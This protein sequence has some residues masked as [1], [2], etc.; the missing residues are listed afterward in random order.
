[1]DATKR[2]TAA[3]LLTFLAFAVGAHPAAGAAVRTDPDIAAFYLGG[4]CLCATV[5][6]AQQALGLADG[7]LGAAGPITGVGYPAGLL[8][9][10]DSAIGASGVNAHLDAIPDGIKITLAGTSQG[11]IVLN[12]VKQSLALRITPNRPPT[13]LSFVTFGDP[14]NATG[15]IVTR[16]PL[17]WLSVPR[18]PLPTPYATTEIVREYDGLSDWPTRPTA[19]SALNAVMGVA[20]VH[21]FYGAAANPSTPGTLKTVAT[22][23][24]GGVTTHYVVPTA[25][26]PITQPLRYMGID[27]APL[28]KWLRP[29]IDATYHQRPQTPPPTSA[30][31]LTETPVDTPATAGTTTPP[32]Q[33]TA[34]DRIR[35]V[36][37]VKTTPGIPHRNPLAAIARALTPRTVRGGSSESTA[38]KEN[39][40]Q[41]TAEHTQKNPRT[42]KRASTRRQSM[43]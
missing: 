24:A 4:T 42:P 28:D 40:P 32:R 11:A 13:E 9:A 41:S 19:L 15:G 3:S 36:L 39:T 18:G 20:F 23:A 5:P 35:S 7:Y 17:L 8:F 6:T 37:R 12:Y 16:N 31:A 29:Q 33:N 30:A 25:A 22:N 10:L 34:A 26:L 43:D 38:A 1:M 21:P 14:M 2:V 27:T